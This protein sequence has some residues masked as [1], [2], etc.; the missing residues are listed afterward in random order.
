M[1]NAKAVLGG[2]VKVVM[3]PFAAIWV[4][5]TSFKGNGVSTK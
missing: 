4:L 3:V 2:V 5:V 1:S